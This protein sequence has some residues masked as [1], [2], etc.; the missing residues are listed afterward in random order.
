[1]SCVN[2]FVFRFQVWRY[3]MQR[4]D[5]S[6]K[7]SVT[8]IAAF[9]VLISAMLVVVTKTSLDFATRQAV[10]Q[11]E[12]NMRVAWEVLHEEGRRFERVGDR[13]TVDGHALNGDYSTVDHIK[14][15]VGGVATI[16]MGDRRVTTNIMKPGGG[17]AVGTPLARGP[18]YDAVLTRGQPMRGEAMILGQ[19]YFAAYDPIR[20]P[21]GDVVGILFVGVA[22]A[23]YFQPVY[24]QVLWMALCGAV[25]AM[26]G[27]LVTV[28]VVRRQLRPLKD[29]RAA[30]QRVMSGDLGVSLPFA[31]RGGDMSQM[32]DAVHAFRDDA[33]AKARIEAEA[34]EIRAAAE[35]ERAKNEALQ[36]GAAREL[37]L[38]VNDLGVGLAK[39]SAGDLTYRLTSAFGHD[40]KKLQDDFN[41]AVAG[42]QKTMAV[43]SGNTAS[44]TT[45][46]GEI[47]QASDDLSRRTE[48][49][50]ASLEETA[51]ALDE[52]TAT[53]R[54]TAEGAQQAHEVVRKAMAD[55]EK[56]GEV[57]DQ[58]V[59]AMGQ[60]ETSSKS[61]GQIIGVIDEIAFQTNLLALN[62]GVEAAR[63]GDAGRGFA[64]VA[65]EVR[66]LAQ[67]S[68]LAAKEI[69]TLVATSNAQ[70]AAGVEWV[71]EAGEALQRIAGQI[72]DISSVVSDIASSAK[73]Q[74]V[75]LAEVNTAVNQM[76]QVTQQNAAM[77]EQSTAASQSLA[78]EAETL[79]QLI[80]QFNLGQ[81]ANGQKARRYPADV[82]RPVGGAQSKL[83]A[84]AGGHLG[85]AAA[86]QGW[87]E[88]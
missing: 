33:R 62:A 52:I 63:A 42:L 35:A 18:V 79:A 54:K 25:L 38:V 67:R 34:L 44:I 81:V 27:T 69:K 12:A 60:I 29:I 77:V 16:F 32:A 59:A 3:L 68:A 14:S 87:E 71:G 37:A 13:L 65:S 78:H 76:D 2:S 48:H 49:Q 86:H 66:A 23:D 26:A 4:F 57:V 75:G 15:L 10:A 61:I 9:S 36:A 24:R 20:N 85:A 21:S 19:P 17:R 83:R 88:C 11:E 72:K 64:V 55:A 46:V 31:G 82:A 73:E 50:A 51:A 22:K 8:V 30:L 47:T 43:I 80:G 41:G 40:Y 58:A 56:S 84:F 70:V 45:G 39:L 1:M 28:A 53:V 5:I 7:V 74:A 6:T